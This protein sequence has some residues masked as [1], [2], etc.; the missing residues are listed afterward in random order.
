MGNGAT[1]QP[2]FHHRDHLASVK[3]ISNGT[4]AE[5]K[6]TVYRPYG[7]KGV[8]TGLHA[9]S[10]GY[11][12]ERHDPETGLVYLNARYYDPVLARF[13]SPDWWDP[14]KP[15]VGTN[16]YAYSDNDPVNKSDRNGHIWGHVGAALAGFGIGFGFDVGMQLAEGKSLGQVSYSGAVISGAAGAV[17]AVG[18][19]AM[20]TGLTGKALAGAT[21][22][23]AGQIA[24]GKNDP[25][26]NT[27]AKNIG[28]AFG[29]A[30]G[31]A[32][33]GIP[34]R[35]TGGSIGSKIAELLG[36]TIPTEAAVKGVEKTTEAIVDGPLGGLGGGG[37]SSS[38][39]KPGSSTSPATAATMSNVTHSSAS[40]N[41]RP[42]IG[43]VS[44]TRSEGLHITLSPSG[45][46]VHDKSDFSDPGTPVG[47]QGSIG[48]GREVG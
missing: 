2:F 4:G 44:G 17:A 24:K 1:A 41:G 34:G 46:L 47:T 33:A 43:N 32:I 31:G 38:S 35:S 45:T 42:G 21:I 29:G 3:V 20:G 6:R 30:F 48:S 19:P 37:R 18:I 28:A 22:G 8:D 36:L 7:D 9:E 40:D 5:V 27:P 13:I 11:I 23:H 26:E 25:S 10:K 14:N 15:G 39:S 16:R 12:G